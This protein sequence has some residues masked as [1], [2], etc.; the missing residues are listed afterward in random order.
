[1][2]ARFFQLRRA[3]SVYVSNQH[4][5]L[6]LIEQFRQSNSYFSRAHTFTRLYSTRQANKEG[7]EANTTSESNSVPT[8]SAAIVETDVKHKVLSNLKVNPR[9]DFMMIFTCGVC[10]TRSVKMACRESY[11]KGVVVARCAGCNNLHLIADR[12]GWFGEPGSVEDFLAAR[13]EDIKRESM[14]SLNL[15]LEDLVGKKIAG[16]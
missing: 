8:P 11:E 4:R 2:A 10:E 12:L 5:N 6:S 14:D 7:S 15:T 3:L 9:H 13:G 1:M 16:E